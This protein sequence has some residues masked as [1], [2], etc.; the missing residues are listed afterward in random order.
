[1][2]R[3]GMLDPLGRRLNHTSM[4]R[5]TYSCTL[6]ASGITRQEL[7]KSSGEGSGF[8]EAVCSLV[9]LQPATVFILL[10][11]TVQDVE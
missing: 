10:R 7:G 11:S 3:G 4:E 1:M 6:S 8:T 5:E 9:S 2:A